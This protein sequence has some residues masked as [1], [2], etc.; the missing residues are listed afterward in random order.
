MTG[1]ES[2]PHLPRRCRAIIAAALATTTI[3]AGACTPAPPI[4]LQ[5]TAWSEQILTWIGT[6][7]FTITGDATSLVVAAQATNGLD[8][9]NRVLLYRHDG[10]AAVDLDVCLTATHPG[11]I[12]QEGV[13]LRVA[14]APSG[15]RAITVT[16][17]VFGHATARYNVH[18]W[19]GAMRHGLPG[20][21]LGS[22]DLS[23]T[24]PDDPSAP[25][26]MCA[27]AIGGTLEIK[28]W[29]AA[30]PEPGWD[31]E[32]AVRTVAIP[33]QWVY[34]GQPGLFAGHIERGEQ[35]AFTNFTVEQRTPAAG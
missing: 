2:T 6:D 1:T 27:R 3:A 16:R 14:S 29:S 9:N 4:D 10:R 5:A 12:T 22:V 24:V 17:N 32:R 35:I 21:L 18:G 20:D 30:A 7:S 34:A 13:A 31:D 23:G 33:Q 8:S 19:D 28:A 11:G 25:R 15:Y 26:R